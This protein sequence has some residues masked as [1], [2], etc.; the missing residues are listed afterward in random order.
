[1]A[2]ISENHGDG[3]RGFLY[4]DGRSKQPAALAAPHC[5]L[6]LE[7][8][9]KAIPRL[10]TFS[11]RSCCDGDLLLT[12]AKCYT[13]PQGAILI[14]Y[15]FIQSTDRAVPVIVNNQPENRPRDWSVDGEEAGAEGQ[16]GMQEYEAENACG[17]EFACAYGKHEI[18]DAAGNVGVCEFKYERNDDRI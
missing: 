7:L 17:N 5:Y 15:S 10:A 4:R 9:S 16:Q 11:S 6:K 2:K 13:K 18:R 14:C 1:M 8:R 3:P 12:L